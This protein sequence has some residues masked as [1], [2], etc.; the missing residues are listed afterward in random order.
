[1]RTTPTCFSLVRQ[2]AVQLR[3]HAIKYI[4]TLSSDNFLITSCAINLL[5]QSKKKCVENSSIVHRNQQSSKFDKF[6]LSSYT[7]QIVSH[8]D[9]KMGMAVDY[10]VF[11]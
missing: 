8:V 11:A 5:F 6:R 4:I 9:V 10:L 3:P 7:L 1:V 2:E